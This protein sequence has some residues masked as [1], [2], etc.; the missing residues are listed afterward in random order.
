MGIAIL[1]V[2]SMISAIRSF[3][4]LLCSLYVQSDDM[5]R[6]VQCSA[7]MYI[8]LRRKGTDWDVS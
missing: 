1:K 3:Q 4:N 2:L 6:S 8:M 7:I 5:K